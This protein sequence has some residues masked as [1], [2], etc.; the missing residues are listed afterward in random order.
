[1]DDLFFLMR[2]TMPLSMAKSL[3]N[4]QHAAVFAYILQQNGYPPGDKPVQPDTPHLKTMRV[5][6]RVVNTHAGGGTAPVIIPGDPKNLSAEPPPSFIPGDTKN[7]PTGGGPTQ[8]ELGAAARSGRDWLYHTHDYSGAR[9]APLAQIDSSNAKRLQVACAFQVGEL[10][11]FQ[12]GPI[13]YQ[14]TMYVTTPR[15]TIALNAS[16]CRPK[17]R[18]TWEPKTIEP[19]GPHANRG[20]AIKDGRIVRGTLDG[21]L[22]EL[23]AQTGELIWA[24]KAADALAGETFTMAPMIFEDLILIGPAG[25]ETGISGWV[26][27]FRL[28]D[29]TEV[30]RFKTVPGVD[31]FNSQSWKNPTGIRLGGGAVWTP[32]SLDSEKGELYVAVAN[33]A[34]DLPAGL[35]PGDNRYSS[36][37][38]ALDVHTGELRWYKQ[39]VPNDSHDWDLTQVSPIFKTKVN[40]QE[41]NLVA[42]V[43]KD[44]I[45][46][47]VD[48][49]THEALYATPVTTIKNVDDPVTPQG[50]SVCPGVLG[51]VEWNGP[52]FNPASNLLYVGAV[53][54]CTTFY[55]AEAARYIPGKAY[56]GGM[57]QLA[58]TSQGW[59]TAVDSSTGKVRWRYR[60]PRPM[61]AAVTTTSGNVVFGGETTGDFIVLDAQSGDVLYRFNTGG[62][63]GG[64]IVTYEIDGKQYIGVMSGRPSG[65]WVDKNP[66]APTVFLFALP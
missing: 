51:G 10:A 63:I 45:L 31:E 38:I 15:S 13:V 52:A 64:G 16:N 40:G 28:S 66:S 18:Q 47:S 12:T 1:M 21:Y 26:G 32:L 23:N 17:W 2:T 56:F 3:S 41:R 6:T 24:R 65:F 25:S 34:P 50:V 44:G 14:G 57:V 43:G 5:L 62:P 61:V 46:R 60:S 55:A 53:D 8:E 19:F 33:P 9:Y 35:R 11:N 27:A 22:L 54:W 48:R 58:D 37:V 42:T 36:S 20:V 29:G 59:L 49:S 4:E 30:W 39:I 7:V